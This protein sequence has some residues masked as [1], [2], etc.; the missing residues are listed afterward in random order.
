[1]TISHMKNVLK[2]VWYQK[3]S[4]KYHQKRKDHDITL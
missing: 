2:I 3:I 1:M 4:D